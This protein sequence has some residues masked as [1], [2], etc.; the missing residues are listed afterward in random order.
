MENKSKLITLAILASAAS[1]GTAKSGENLTGDIWVDVQ[2]K[3]T[4]ITKAYIRVWLPKASWVGLSL[5]SSGMDAGTDMI[6]IDGTAKQAYDKVSL[7]YQYPKTDA[8]DSLT[9]K[10]T[11][12]DST[13]TYVL[14]ERD[15][16]TNDSQDYVIPTEKSFSIGWALSTYTSE[17]TNVHNKHGSFR[18]T[19]CPDGCPDMVPDAATNLTGVIATVAA[20]LALLAF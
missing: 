14:I 19:L 6:Q 4:D 5:G 1:A 15:L 10:F 7:G 18:L 12:K 8:I 16:D 17:V 9:S 2:L 11:D 13:N 20:T 3:S